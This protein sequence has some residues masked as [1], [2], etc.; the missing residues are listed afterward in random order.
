MKRLISCIAVSLLLLAV[1]MPVVAHAQE[2]EGWKFSAGTFIWMSDV[3]LEATGNNTTVDGKVD[4][5]DLLDSLEFGLSA[6]VMARKDKLSF[7]VDTLNFYLAQD[8]DSPSGGSREVNL[9]LNWLQGLVGYRVFETQVG[10]ESKLSIE[11]TAGY[12]YYW[13]RFTIDDVSGNEVTDKKSNWGDL[14]CGG[15][16][17]YDLNPKWSF[18]GS[19]T[20]GGF[21][22]SNS[23][24]Y[25]WTAAA[26]V[27]WHFA[28]NKTLRFGYLTVCVKKEKDMDGAL[29]DRLSIK[30]TMSGP[31]ISMV[32][33]F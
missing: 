23:S 17:I 1:V 4:F 11:P 24:K 5:A 14:V 8:I 29:I 21:D 31:L 2:S 30:E 20:Y 25:S 26:L 10:D 13:N 12:R 32:W 22:M 33:N 18:I 28:K 16:I 6:D 3:E 9:S 19:G 15:R 27:D 7:Q